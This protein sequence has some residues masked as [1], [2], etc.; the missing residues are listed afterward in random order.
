MLHRMI[1]NT[2]VSLL[3]FSN[4]ALAQSKVKHLPPGVEFVSSGSSAPGA[5][6]AHKFLFKNG[7]RLLV[8]PDSRNPVATFKVIM[9]A[10]SNRERP[11]QTGLAHFFEHMMFRKT[12]VTE[13]GHYDRVLASVGGHGNAW[14]SNN[15]VA[16]YSV[17]PGPA[18]EKMLT[19]EA[20]RFLSLSLEN[21]YFNT[22]KGAVVSERRMRLENNPSQRG[23]EILRR[24]S[25]KDSTYEWETLGS[26]EDVQ[27]MSI[28]NAM[29]FYEKFYTPD[30]AVMTIGGPFDVN[31]VVHLVHKHFGKWNRK[32]GEK[33]IK[34]PEDYFTRNIGKEF[35]CSEEVSSQNVELTYPSA[36]TTYLSSM[37]AWAFLELL[38]SHP[39]G[40]FEKRLM[41]EKL[42]SGF[43][44]YKESWNGPT[45]PYIVS[46]KLNNDQ[47]LEPAV[48]F[49]E[50]ALREVENKE[51]TEEFKQKLIKQIDVSYARLVEKMSSLSQDY[52]LAEFLYKDYSL[53]RT[54]HHIAE[55]INT[56]QMKEWIQKSLG[57][58]KFFTSA[59][60]KK[61]TAIPCEQ[62]DKNLQKKE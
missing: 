39:D 32:L 9:Q 6:E 62:F 19:V 23:M 13:E 55:K 47:K 58:K 2:S 28:E 50:K 61:G 24:A 43:S 17:F 15:A 53:T 35:I 27:N 44:F 31:E 37:M 26:K 29:K 38:S 1:I 42:A 49:W 3:F 54:D 60:V 21:P 12:K 56:Q 34:L 22:E 59:I 4:F 57:P 18:L 51:I 36:D 7:L 33:E 40:T 14:T 30:N 45:Q 10:G 48:A 46:F 8:V 11:G 16:Y 5:V 20:Q 52:E 41:K 25:E